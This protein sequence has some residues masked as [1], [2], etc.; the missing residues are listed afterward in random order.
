LL[1]TIKESNTTNTTIT[2]YVETIVGPD[3]IYVEIPVDTIQIKHPANGRLLPYTFLIAE[4]FNSSNL[5]PIYGEDI[6]IHESFELEYYNEKRLPEMSFDIT[7]NKKFKITTETFETISIEIELD[8]FRLT[9]N[10]MEIDYHNGLECD[11]TIS[12]SNGDEIEIDNSYNDFSMYIRDIITHPENPN[13]PLA[14]QFII[15]SHGNLIDQ[16]K[17]E[18]IYNYQDY[19]IAIYGMVMFY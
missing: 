15:E 17:R 6:T 14:M 3:T 12:K 16:L 2:R 11:L 18:G 19:N 10:V 1:D 7:L 8:D 9:N 5:Y 4:Q 13:I